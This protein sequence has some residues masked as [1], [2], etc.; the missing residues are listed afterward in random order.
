M[1]IKG[2]DG[3]SYHVASSATGNTALGLGIAGTAIGLLNGGVGKIFGE[4]WGNNGCSDNMPVNRYELNLVTALSSK[5]GEIALLK[6]DN[7]TDKKIVEA[8]AYL[9]GEIGKVAEKLE[10]FKDSQNE[11][12]MQQS[13]YNGVN[14]ATIQCMQNQISQLLGL[15]KL[16]VP[17]ASV[18]PGWGNVNIT[19]ATT[20][21][22]TPA[23]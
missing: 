11:F 6:A 5:D 21:T 9:Q 10:K 19:P 13:T 7:Y 12:N 2:M 18:C 17:N 4:N 22:T 23:A 3:Q 8:T 15:T 20:G 16:V 1:Q 14:T